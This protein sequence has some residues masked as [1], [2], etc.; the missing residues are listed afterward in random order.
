MLA[1]S[2]VGWGLLAVS[3]ALGLLLLWMAAMGVTGRLSL[4]V[5]VGRSFHALGPLTVRMNAPRKTVFEVVSAPYL[6][7]PSQQAAGSVEVLERGSDMVVAAHRTRLR[8]FTAITVETVRFEPPQRVT[9]GLLR[10]P[11]PHVEEEFVLRDADGGTEF[12]YQGR[13]AMDFW[14][15]G[16]LVGR[17]VAAPTWTSVVR[18]HLEDVKRAAEERAR[19]AR[20]RRG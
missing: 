15:L 7:R 13:L 8:F 9:F 4:D 2:A 6:G 19:A 5:G 16:R 10:G 12:S 14:I 17:F 3:V 1:I 11:V 20:R 18:R